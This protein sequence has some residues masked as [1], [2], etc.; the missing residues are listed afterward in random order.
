MTTL[1]TPLICPK[2]GEDLQLEVGEYAP[3]NELDLVLTCECGD[4]PT[5]NAFVAFDDFIE[6]TE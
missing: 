6:V 1:S 2:C 5:L 4:Q 3:N